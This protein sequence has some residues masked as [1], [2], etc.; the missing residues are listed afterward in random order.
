MRVIA[1]FRALFRP[2]LPGLACISAPWFWT[3][4]WQRCESEAMGDLKS[5][6]YSDFRSI[7]E[8][9]AALQPAGSLD[10]QTDPIIAAV[11][12]KSRRSEGA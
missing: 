11:R 12:R 8:V 5:G 4:T 10:E 7:D 9:I 3:R 1:F 2:A 6:D